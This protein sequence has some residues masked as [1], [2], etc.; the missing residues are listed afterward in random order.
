M[1]IQEEYLHYLHLIFSVLWIGLPALFLLKE[2][3]EIKKM[4]LNSKKNYWTFLVTSLFISIIISIILM[5]SKD[6][7]PTGAI[8]LTIFQTIVYNTL[9]FFVETKFRLENRDNLKT[10]HDKVIH[11]FAEFELL[12]RIF[13]D[14]IE[15]DLKFNKEV[16]RHLTHIDDFHM[17]ISKLKLETYFSEYFVYDSKNRVIYDIPTPYFEKRIW[18]RFVEDS[19]HYYSIQRMSIKD[20]QSSV[21]LENEDRQTQEINKL[22]SI[23]NSRNGNSDMKKIFIIDEDLFEFSDGVFNWKEITGD[24]EKKEFSDKLK[25]YLCK[26]YNKFKEMRCDCS[27]K[28]PI[29]IIAFSDAQGKMPLD[30]GIFGDVY[31]IQSKRVEKDKIIVD[32]LSIDFYFNKTDTDKRIDEFKEHFNDSKSTIC[33]YSI[34][35]NAISN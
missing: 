2:R 34:F 4:F 9:W 26:W 6:I 24:E 11:N 16:K 31:G 35:D 25:N 5:N 10:E 13:F 32:E 29:K 17:Y 21:Y 33:L 28:F 15:N 20:K 1:K 22:H 12:Q 30:I 27:Y 14:H 19:K 18:G 23:L 3:R 7:S 8:I